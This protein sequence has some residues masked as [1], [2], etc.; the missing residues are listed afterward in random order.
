MPLPGDDDGDDEDSL[1]YWVL[2]QWLR[3]SQSAVYHLV[4][5]GGKKQTTPLEEYED[6][7]TIELMPYDAVPKTQTM[8]VMEHG[9]MPGIKQPIDGVVGIAEIADAVRALDC[10]YLFG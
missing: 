7:V 5:Y 6:V 8:A 9:A 2:A 3:E 4:A 1:E 10:C